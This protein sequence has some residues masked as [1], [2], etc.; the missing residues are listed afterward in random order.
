MRGA[1]PALKVSW[2]ARRRYFGVCAQRAISSPDWI[3]RNVLRGLA[4]FR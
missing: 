1:V 2:V 4:N 3:C